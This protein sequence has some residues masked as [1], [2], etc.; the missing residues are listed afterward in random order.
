MSQI[1]L[2]TL[3]TKE[4]QLRLLETHCIVREVLHAQQRLYEY[5][6]KPDKQLA[7]LLMD[8]EDQSW[9]G[10]RR[11]SDG[12]LTTTVEEKLEC[13]AQFYEV[14]YTSL[15]PSHMAIA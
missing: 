11:F 3:D 5:R 4:T 14:L 7:R 12:T 10:Q 8:S 2:E 1:T 6:D 15:C 13:F 9:G